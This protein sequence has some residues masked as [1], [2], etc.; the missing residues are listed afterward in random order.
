MYSIGTAQ[1]N[2]VSEEMR[3]TIEVAKIEFV[4]HSILQE[5]AELEKSE[6]NIENLV[7]YLELK[8]IKDAKIVLQQAILESGWLRSGS[9]RNYN[10]L[11]GMK[12]ANRRPTTATGTGLGHASYAHWT[13]SVKDYMLWREYWE[14]KGHDT[15]DYY[16]FLKKVGYAES[17]IYIAVLKSINVEKEFKKITKWET[18]T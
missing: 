8:E 3:Q 16:K 14:N 12:Y 7:K 4:R 5:I 2:T 9:A 10:N 18:I 13:D 17:T 6:L 15:S 1:L 11:F